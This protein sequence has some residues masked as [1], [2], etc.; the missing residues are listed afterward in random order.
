[1]MCL[2]RRKVLKVLSNEWI[3]Q[4][5][6]EGGLDVVYTLIKMEGLGGGSGRNDK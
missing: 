5:S 3:E 1:M 6:R 2:H 4:V